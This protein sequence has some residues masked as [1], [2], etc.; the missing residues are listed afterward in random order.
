MSGD[1]FTF[2]FVDC[3]NGIRTRNEKSRKRRKRRRFKMCASKICKRSKRTRALRVF[4]EEPRKRVFRRRIGKC[5]QIV[6]SFRPSQRRQRS[7]KS[8]FSLGSKLEIGRGEIT[9]VT[10]R[11]RARFPR[12]G[13]ARAAARARGARVGDRQFYEWGPH[14]VRTLPRYAVYRFRERQLGE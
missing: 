5:A 2:L 8:D 6:A 1:I 3:Q 14:V 7:F 12:E 13:F 4:L 9:A 10:A 11:P